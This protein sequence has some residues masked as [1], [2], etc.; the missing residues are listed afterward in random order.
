MLSCNLIGCGSK[1]PRAL[2]RNFTHFCACVEANDKQIK[3]VWKHGVFSVVPA[4]LD[5]RLSSIAEQLSATIDEAKS[6][7]RS[8]PQ[9]TPFLPETVRLHVTQLLGLGCS[10]GQVKSMCLRQPVLLTYN[11]NS[12]VH[13]AK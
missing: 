3:R 11:Y 4:D 12:D 13:V 2:H 10:H 9:L 1:S 7:L 6:M 8:M 5:A